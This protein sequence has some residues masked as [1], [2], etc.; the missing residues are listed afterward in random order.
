MP[1]LPENVNNIGLLHTNGDSSLPDGTLKN[2]I[3]N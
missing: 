3:E 1:K 2:R